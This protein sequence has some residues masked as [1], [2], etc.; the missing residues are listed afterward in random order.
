MIFFLF[1][2]DIKIP[3][4]GIREKV[5]HEVDGLI[6]ISV[7]FFFF[8]LLLKLLMNFLSKELNF[9]LILKKNLT[10]FPTSTTSRAMIRTSQLQHDK[11]TVTRASDFSGK[12]YLGYPM[13]HTT[14]IDNQLKDEE[15]LE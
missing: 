2:D 9:Y 11:S 14:E 15:Y 10:S 5:T 1:L 12:K 6:K 8:F 3:L 7:I 13:R 4:I